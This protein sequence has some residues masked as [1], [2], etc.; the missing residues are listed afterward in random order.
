[1]IEKKRDKEEEEEKLILEST[2]RGGAFPYQLH[3]EMEIVELQKEMLEEVD[4]CKK[5]SLQA[6]I[7]SKKLELDSY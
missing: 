6:Q 7:I 2:P 4:W 1:M 5:A 3:M